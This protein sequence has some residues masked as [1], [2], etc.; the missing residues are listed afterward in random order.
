MIASRSPPVDYIN[1][2]PPKVVVCTTTLN[3]QVLATAAYQ[4]I[5]CGGIAKNNSTPASS[6]VVYEVYPPKN[7][8]GGF[9]YSLKTL[10]TKP[11]VVAGTSPIAQQNWIDSILRLWWLD[12]AL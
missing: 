10:M 2:L 3:L 1:K 9:A 4:T 11:S 12:G 8:K 6:K 7:M 5:T